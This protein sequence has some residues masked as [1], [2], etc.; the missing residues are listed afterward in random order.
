MKDSAYSANYQSSQEQEH[1]WYVART[2]MLRHE[3]QKIGLPP[4]AKILDYGAGTGANLNILAQF[5][6][7][8]AFEPSPRARELGSRSGF[9]FFSDVKALEPGSYDL[10]S[11]LDVLE[12]IDDDQKALLAIRALLKENGRL[13]ITVPAFP[14]LWSSNDE[15]AEH[16][17][18]YRRRELMSLAHRCGFESLSCRYWN[19]QTWPVLFLASFVE[20]LWK[21][22]PGTRDS[23]SSALVGTP[24]KVLN[25]LL[26]ASLSLEQ[27]HSLPFGVSLV[28]VLEKSKQ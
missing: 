9:N 19:S 8:D 15:I 5:G 24:P 17:R 12:H 28:Q 20:K 27:N 18:R 2:K 4:Q 23:E 3:I 16:R 11:L 6:N 13:L 25:N 21:K 14:I 26:S 1:W 22:K 7:V 10:I